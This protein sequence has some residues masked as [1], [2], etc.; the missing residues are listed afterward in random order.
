MTEAHPHVMVI[1]DSAV[2]RRITADVLRQQGGMRVTTAP[3]PYVA[4]GKIKL[5]RPDVLL[6]DV[7]MPRK[8]GITFLR[9]IMGSDPMP[10]VI[11]SGF[12][13][14]G[15]RIAID[16]LTLGAVDVVCKPRHGIRE[17]LDTDAPRL[18]QVLR[19]AAQAQL[20]G[21]LGAIRRVNPEDSGPSLPTGGPA[22][23]SESLV[24]RMI[25]SR[26]GGTERIV[27]IG[28]STGGPQALDVVLGAMP[29]DCPP[30]LVVQHM[31]RPFTTALAKRLDAQCEIEVREARDG[32][33][34]TRGLALIARG[35]RHLELER[36]PELTVVLSGAEPVNNHRPSVDVLFRSLARSTA[37]A[38]IGVLLT[39]MGSDGAQG[40]AELKSVG[41]ATVVQDE[42]TC[43]VFG[44]PRQAIALG[45]A[46]SVVSLDRVARTILDH[47][48]EELV[49][50]H[51]R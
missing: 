37:S 17:F 30:L 32:D 41:A 28:A 16:A 51:R 21:A 39:G 12:A 49:V 44:M 15:T 4:Q 47:C 46:D 35:D 23:G 34:P 7:E 5:D 20:P 38:S 11:Y 26:A 18:I 6:L 50:A 8:D 45:A 36:S 33:R 29:V 27:A 22:A 10:V 42:A 25:R 14:R 2:V 48:C 9:E 31:P 40:L 43:V 3:D 19:G 24:S 13:D 1:D